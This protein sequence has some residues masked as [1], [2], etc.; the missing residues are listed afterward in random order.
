MGLRRECVQPSF[1]PSRPGSLSLMTAQWLEVEVKMID[2]Q[3]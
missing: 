3:L 2:E 1:R